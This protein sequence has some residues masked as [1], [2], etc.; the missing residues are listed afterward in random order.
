MQ[1]SKNTN[2]TNY[3]LEVSEQLKA[4][5]YD[6]EIAKVLRFNQ[7]LAK[8]YY[9]NMHGRGLLVAHAMGQGKTRIAVA[10]TQAMLKKDPGRKPIILLPKSLQDNFVKSIQE[11]TTDENAPSKYKFV[12][13]NA[14]N[15]AK[16]M[17]SVDRTKEELAY[18]KRL[19]NLLADMKKG[20][21]L[22]NTLLVIDE[23]HNLFNAITNGSKNAVQLYDLIMKTTD[24]KI[25][26]L[27]GTPIV[28]DPF[29][30]VACF[31]ML[32][33]AKHISGHKI[34]L[35]SEER[36]EFEDYFI[37]RK[38]KTIK[39]K[40][41]FLNRIYGLT[42][43]FGDLYFPPAGKREGFPKKL[44]TIIEKVPMSEKQFGNYWSARISEQDENK[45]TYR[46][47]QARFSSSSGGGTSYRV[48]SRQISNFAIP[49]YA[50]GPIRGRKA[51]LKFIDK[52]KPDDLLD[53]DTWSPKMQRMLTNILRHKSTNGMVYS[54]F[55]SG[56]G[57]AIFARV[58]EVN[59]YENY[60]DRIETTGGLEVY[61]GFSAGKKKKKKPCFAI[62]SGD[63]SV[64]QRSQIIET[65]NQ[66][67]NHDGSKIHMLLLSG[68]VAEGIDLKRIRH[69]H[70]MEP[71]WNYA[72]INQVETRAIRYGSHTDLPKKDQNVQVYIYLS[73]YP[74]NYPKKKIIENTTDVEL[75]KKSLDN[76]Q[77]INTFNLAIAESSLDCSLHH[78]RLPASIK[79]K[80]NCKLCSPNDQPL[81][82]PVLELDMKLPDNCTPLTEQ[83]QKVRKITLDG[84]DFFY[85]EVNG[86][87]KLYHYDKQLRGH[88][89]LPRSHPHY[90]T[91]MEK[92]LKL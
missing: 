4:L 42:S 84:E 7:F 59:G 50:R 17:L 12:S 18:E 40:N 26:F 38:K 92:I 73:T 2:S 35:F 77:I 65:F 66:K 47:S 44:K 61:G 53:L 87:T 24:I 49:N 91:L 21:S 43:Y 63:I 15:M 72:R 48:K 64:E 78:D 31:N 6:K 37:D 46:S 20:S 75:F 62:L 11:F 67:E 14:S 45:K 19:G 28:N 10:I 39:N 16:Q 36:N 9:M 56:E 74:K 76:M 57:L 3:P 90:G 70:I 8:E 22:E 69:V 58:L 71:F 55:V 25:I 52:I 5:S 51:R 79:K 27:S 83:K 41:K 82:N 85:N 32:A 89:L 88:T 30:L 23:A 13:L 60:L 80:I 1:L 86:D 54:Q 33:G 81:Y 68:A 29:E 34:T